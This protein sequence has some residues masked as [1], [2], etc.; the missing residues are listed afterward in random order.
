M[1]TAEEDVRALA[2]SL[3]PAASRPARHLLGGEILRMARQDGRPLN[4]V[5]RGSYPLT[6]ENLALSRALLSA[7]PRAQA[8]SDYLTFYTPSDIRAM[9]D[10]LKAKYD[11]VNT[12]AKGDAQWDLFYGE[13]VKFHDEQKNRFGLTYSQS[14]VDQI[15][16]RE[17]ELAA[18]QDKL[19]QK[20]IDTG[21]KPSP[22]TPTGDA[23]GLLESFTK[24]ALVAG[25]VYVA[26]KV[27][28]RF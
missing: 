23:K 14:T 9:L 17:R 21:P 5:L 16:Q 19:A 8:I 18:W 11:A 27:I 25:G 1:G 3:D 15:R 28:G 24:A 2:R 7:P 26:V 12:K 22:E 4:E 6:A 20:G 10:A 13:F